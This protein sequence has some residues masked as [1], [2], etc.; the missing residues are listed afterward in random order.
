[1][2]ARL[3]RRHVRLAHDAERPLVDAYRRGDLS[4]RGRDRTLRV[5]RTIAD[6]AA[7]DD[8]LRDDVVSALGYRQEATD[9]LGAAA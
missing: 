2:D 6:L 8:V 9:A 1:M 3:V 4:A 7:R 5:A